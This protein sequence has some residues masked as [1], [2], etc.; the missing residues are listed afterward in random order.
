MKKKFIILL[1]AF[2][3]GSKLLQA[4]LSNSKELFSLPAYPLLYLPELYESWR[5]KYK[6]NSEKLF[7]L[8]NIQFA[9]IF[10][11]RNLAGFNGTD[12][13]GK[14]KDEYIAIPKEK[15]KK[16]FVEYFQSNEINL[17]NL[18]TA[19][20]TS[21][22]KTVGN[23]CENILYHVHSLGIYNNKLSPLYEN[24]KKILTIRDPI[25]NFWR[26]EYATSN[27]SMSR[28]DK[29]DYENLK[30]FQYINRLM[31][32][33][34][35]FKNFNYSNLLN[36]KI[37]KFEN[38]KLEQTTT[39]KSIC[40]FIKINYDENQMSKPMFNNKQWWGSKIYKGSKENYSYEKEKLSNL[41]DKNKFSFYEIFLLNS[42]LQPFLK[43]YNYENN[44]KNNYIEKFLFWFLIFLPTKYG[45][46]LFL[47]RFHYLSIFSYIKNCYRESFHFT[48]KNYYF[49][50]M[51]KYK[52]SY[53]YCYLINFN[54]VRKQLFK[55][56]NFL[57][58]IFNFFIKIILYPIFQL[59]LV[60]LYIFRIILIILIKI[61][62]KKNIKY[63][64]K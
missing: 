24:T 60:I 9:S 32:M 54:F 61:N 1:C 31:D 30:N 55:S 35:N 42:I 17:K 47:K 50:A 46:K 57:L 13:L 52:W 45:T 51:Y 25:K 53:K 12:K 58:S 3:S 56:K 38:F 2:G 26:S 10:D 5:I 48:L 39:I 18:I 36:C 22:Q 29:S 27:I 28:Y 44:L 64:V 49:N 34:I 23:N 16:Y 4:H 59:E 6:L 7:D 14:N 19:I 63:S 43:K 41:E 62:V 15:F 33:Y 20:H 21:Y 40:D 8:L 37:I 11:S